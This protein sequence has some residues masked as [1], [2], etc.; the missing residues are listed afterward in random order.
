LVS[1]LSKGALQKLLSGK[2]KQPARV[3]V[4]F[5][6]NGCHY[7][8]E[9]KEDFEQ[10]AADDKSERLFFAFNVDDYPAVQDILNFQG[11]PT[12]CA[13]KVG[14]SKPKIKVMPEPEKPNK[15]TWYNTSEIKLF[16]EAEQ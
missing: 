3:V 15:D 1:R 12:I 4:K 11:V 5:Y 14:D 9:L 10:I 7:C 13:M 6:N 16:I 8:H 2:V